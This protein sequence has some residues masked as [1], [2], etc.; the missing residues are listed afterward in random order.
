MEIRDISQRIYECGIV[1]VVKIEEAEQAARLART[2]MAGGI[3]CIEVTFRTEAA[4]QAIENISRECPDML[5]GAGTVLTKEQVDD[6]ADAGAKFIVTPGFNRKIAAYCLEK[7]IPIFPGCNN[8]AVIE[9][10]LEMGI[11]DLKFFPAEQ[12]G[13]LS[14]I[15]ALSA[16][17]SKIRFI[18]TGGVNEENMNEYLANERVLACGGTWMVKEALIQNRQFDEIER[19]T[20]NAVKKMLGFELRHIGI[21]CAHEK[22]AVQRADAVAELFGLEVKNGNSSVFAGQAFEMM[23]KE[24]CGEHGHICMAVNQL[25]R[26]YANFRHKGIA[27]DEESKKLDKKGNMKVIN[28]KEP[29]GGFVL[30]MINK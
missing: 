25:D 13:G 26:A 1:P 11:T 24:G 23:K 14:M 20:R 28:F 22:E 16:P 12:S 7:K 5:V 9:E 19:L 6:A 29:I 10:A 27:F 8:P 2:L 18:P 21:N 3:R 4:K 30:Q 17:Y 15:K